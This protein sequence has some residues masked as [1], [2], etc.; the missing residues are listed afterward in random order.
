MAA[1]QANSSPANGLLPAVG[2]GRTSRSAALAVQQ[3]S[4]GF[5][6]MSA[7]SVLRE[8]SPSRMSKQATI[9]PGGMRATKQ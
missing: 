6:G 1:G 3:G 9:L 2:R 7:S 4:V 5:L 8:A